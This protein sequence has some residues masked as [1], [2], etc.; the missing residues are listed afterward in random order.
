MT[1]AQA[2]LAGATDV[3]PV[4]ASIDLPA[5][6]GRE[7]NFSALVVHA[8]DGWTALCEDLEVAAD[9]DDAQ[10]AFENLLGAVQAVLSVDS[11]ES[12][13]QTPEGDVLELIGSHVG[14]EPVQIFV[15]QVNTP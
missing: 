7:R 5:S 8:A 15:F 1:L 9:G 11:V 2:H 14:P 6:P 10:D 3:E 13:P 12:R 4:V